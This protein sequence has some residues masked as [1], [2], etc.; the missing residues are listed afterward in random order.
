MRCG[1]AVVKTSGRGVVGLWGCEAVGWR[2]GGVERWSVL[3]GR[4]NFTSREVLMRVRS[5]EP[6]RTINTK[7]HIGRFSVIRQR[8]LQ[9][10]KVS[11][12]LR[13][14]TKFVTT[15]GRYGLFCSLRY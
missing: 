6:P 12:R 3:E 7:L 9:T 1:D 14:L 10:S 8:P 13:P 4:T 5:N 11:L 2:G 15:R